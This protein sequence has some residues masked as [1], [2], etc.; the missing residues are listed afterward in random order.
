MRGY[1]TVDRYIAKLLAWA[2]INQALR[3]CRSRRPAESTAAEQFMESEDLI[4]WLELLGIK[5]EIFYKN[6]AKIKSLKLRIYNKPEKHLE[7]LA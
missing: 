2:V 4:F 6:L 1:T 5:P 3:D 7:Q